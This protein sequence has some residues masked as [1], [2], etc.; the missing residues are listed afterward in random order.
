[1]V[2]PTDSTKRIEQRR[3]IVWIVEDRFKVGDK[4]P[5]LDAIV[6]RFRSLLAGSRLKLADD[7]M[8]ALVREL[9]AEIGFDPDDIRERGY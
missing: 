8:S 7:D 2:A 1:M 6:V 4:T 3:T 5:S 9:L